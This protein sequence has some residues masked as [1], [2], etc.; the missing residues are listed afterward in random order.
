LFFLK[1][2]ITINLAPAELKKEGSAFDLP[3]ALGI[4][5]CS[6]YISSQTINKHCFVGE[7]SLDGDI[8]PAKGVLPMA[9]TIKEN[10]GHSL[11]VPADNIQEA[12]VVDKID[13]YPLDNLQQTSGFHK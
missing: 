9:L 13:T 3:I 11:C 4:L 6:G 1:K 12:A 2:R 8:R 5:A 10:S 7:L